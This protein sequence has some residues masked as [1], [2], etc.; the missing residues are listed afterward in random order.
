MAM[1]NGEVAV[2]SLLFSSQC[3]WCV[4]T[5]SITPPN[6]HQPHLRYAAVERLEGEAKERALAQ[7]VTKKMT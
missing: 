6:H 4:L 3:A 5:I 1:A 7:V 2:S